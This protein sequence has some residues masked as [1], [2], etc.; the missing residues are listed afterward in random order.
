M[1]L[2]LCWNSELALHCAPLFYPWIS[3]RG[4]SC[5]EPFLTTVRSFPQ[6]ALREGGFI[7]LL[8][9]ALFILLAMLS[10]NPSDPAWSVQGSQLVVHN[11]VGRTGAWV[12]DV[13]SPGG[14]ANCRVGGARHILFCPVESACKPAFPATGRSW[15]NDRQLVIRAGADESALGRLNSG[16]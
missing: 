13:L 1:I 9:L 11:L 7:V 10:Y 12:A 8:T 14:H 16:G 3:P 4:S 2:S 6:I 5:G 15:W